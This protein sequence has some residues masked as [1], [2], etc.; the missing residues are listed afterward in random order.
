M[1]EM[2]GW[3]S[4]LDCAFAIVEL[5]RNTAYRRPT[6]GSAISTA[7]S[8]GFAREGTF[9]CCGGTAARGPAAAADSHDWTDDKIHP[10]GRG[11]R[12][13]GESLELP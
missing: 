2:V 12:R 7:A 11:Y 1:R 10:S 9:C 4:G 13:L 3:A 8:H 6:R 5:S